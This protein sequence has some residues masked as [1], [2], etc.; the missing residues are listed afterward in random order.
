MNCH[1]EQGICPECGS[2]DLK[3][4][5]ADFEGNIIMYPWK[6]NTCEAVGDECY[7]MEF[8]EHENIRKEVK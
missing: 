6:C 5:S 8:I 7:D 3:Y 2:E 4:D 1:H